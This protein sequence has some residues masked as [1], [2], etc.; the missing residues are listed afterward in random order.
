MI[1]LAEECSELSAII[2]KL[3]RKRYTSNPTPKCE[4]D[5]MDE[6]REEFTDV[7]ICMDILRELYIDR[8]VYNSKIERWLHRL[9][10]RSEKND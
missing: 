7:Y 6:I 10:E 8:Q 5:I 2:T 3:V 9:K 4:D 1:Q